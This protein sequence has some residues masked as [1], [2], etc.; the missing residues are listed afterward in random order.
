MEK[1]I[2]DVIESLAERI[3]KDVKSADALRFTQSV[4]NLAHAL[5]V[6]AAVDKK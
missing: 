6:M 3:S 4:L 5:Q 1:S 2:N